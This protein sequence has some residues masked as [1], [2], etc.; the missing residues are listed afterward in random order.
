MCNDE[1]MSPRRTKEE[2]MK[3]RKRKE[4][5]CIQTCVPRAH[6]AVHTQRERESEDDE[7]MCVYV[8]VHTYVRACLA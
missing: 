8:C 3:K 6:V 4:I 5:V 7:R 1:C 2:N